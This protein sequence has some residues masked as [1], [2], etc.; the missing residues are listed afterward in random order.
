MSNSV[1]LFH[2][3]IFQQFSTVSYDML[4]VGDCSTTLR[5]DSRGPWS[6]EAL[7]GH[8]YTHGYTE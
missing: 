4:Q 6:M 2:T 1:L 5:H 7:K 3:K 8:L